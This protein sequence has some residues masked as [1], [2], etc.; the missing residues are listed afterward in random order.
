MKQA[1]QLMDLKYYERKQKYPFS[2]I[3][4][5]NINEESTGVIKQTVYILT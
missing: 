1:F 2:H 5:K 3:D 4:I